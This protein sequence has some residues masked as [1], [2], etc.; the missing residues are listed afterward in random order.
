MA[1]GLR[2]LGLRPLGLSSFPVSSSSSSRRALILALGQLKEVPDNLLGTGLKPLVLV[3]GQVQERVASE[4]TPLI[5]D[6]GQLRTLAANETLL[7]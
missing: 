2:P 1:L 3:Q 5:L 4:G 6:Q 7:I